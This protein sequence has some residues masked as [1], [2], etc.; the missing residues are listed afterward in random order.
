MTAF[1]WHGINQYALQAFIVCVMARQY[2]WAQAWMAVVNASAFMLD[3][4]VPEIN[5]VRITL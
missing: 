4:L 1:L 5:T 3:L 2:R